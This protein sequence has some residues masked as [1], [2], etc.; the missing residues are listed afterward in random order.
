MNRLSIL[1]LLI[2]K[3]SKLKLQYSFYSSSSNKNRIR[4]TLYTK[5]ECSL[6]DKAKDDLKETYG[7]LFELEEVNILK[8]RDLFRK[9]KLDIPVFYFNGEI[10]M[11]HK[12]DKLKLDDLIKKIK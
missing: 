10:L 9:F 11:Q 7:D 3:K 8:S 5:P 1:N 12:I 4:L 6:C 2:L